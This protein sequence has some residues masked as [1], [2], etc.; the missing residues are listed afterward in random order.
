MLKKY[1][2]RI[3]QGSDY[4]LQVIL[5]QPLG[6]AMNLTGFTAQAEIKLF[7]SADDVAAEMTC[8]IDEDA[9]T[10]ILVL[11]LDNTQTTKLTNNYY[12]YDL[13]IESNNI[14]TKVLFGDV[15]VTSQITEPIIIEP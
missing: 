3:A 12:V 10:G 11:S 9:T 14:K 4:G 8:T 5:Q 15:F 2:L 13:F 6:T 1:D 7:T